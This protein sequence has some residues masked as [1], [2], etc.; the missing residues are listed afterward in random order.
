MWDFPFAGNDSSTGARESFRAWTRFTSGLHPLPPPRAAL[1]PR[2]HSYRPVNASVCRPLQSRL[3]GLSKSRRR[4]QA[5]VNCAALSRSVPELPL[6]HLATMVVCPAFSPAVTL[7]LIGATPR[8]VCRRRRAAHM[9]KPPPP[10]SVRM[11]R[12][13]RRAGLGSAEDIE[14]FL[15]RRSSNVG[16]RTAGAVV[17]LVRGRSVVVHPRCDALAFV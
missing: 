5:G 11:V 10:R 8:P 12:V 13:A 15:R 1:E 14:A 9:S 3:R 16:M 4:L 7:P 6:S 17:E 2:S